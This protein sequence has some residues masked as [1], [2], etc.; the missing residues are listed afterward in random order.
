M[1]RKSINIQQISN[2]NK[3]RELYFI[4]NQRVRYIYTGPDSSEIVTVLIFHSSSNTDP[5]HFNT[6]FFLLCDHIC[7]C[8][9]FKPRTQAVKYVKLVLVLFFN[10]TEK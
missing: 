9:A 10:K 1:I 3:M 8:R 2:T 4:F 5:L 6:F 7:I